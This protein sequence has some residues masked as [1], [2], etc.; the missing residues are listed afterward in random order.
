MDSMDLMTAKRPNPLLR[1][2]NS[3][4]TSAVVPSTLTLPTKPLHAASFPTVAAA[5]SSTSSTTSSANSSSQPFFELISIKPLSYTSLKD[6]LPSSAVNS[7]TSSAPAQSGYEI[8]IRN[9]LVKQAA[10]AYLQPMSTSP[11]SGGRHFLCR[12]RS[13][14]SSY[15][16]NNPFTSFLRFLS[17]SISR[18]FD[19]LLRFIRSFR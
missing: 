8:S 12:F 17:R 1:R 18:A 7:P 3:I 19:H 15:L 6:L 16:L 9:R 14:I 13:K 11:G 4:A 2:R 5:S 10:W